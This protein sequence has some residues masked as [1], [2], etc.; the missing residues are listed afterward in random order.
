MRQ[1]AERQARTVAAADGAGRVTMRVR[2]P[3]R[4]AHGFSNDTRN[5]DPPVAGGLPRVRPFVVNGGFSG[6]PGPETT[7]GFLAC[8]PGGA[9]AIPRPSWRAGRS[10]PGPRARPTR[11]RIPGVA[12]LP[13]Q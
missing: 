8:F 9:G 5:R 7:L 11:W 13:S 3:S 4:C 12:S 1:G 6:G 10:N 2:R